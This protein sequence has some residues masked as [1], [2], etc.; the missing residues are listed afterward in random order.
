MLCC[1]CYSEMNLIKIF[2]VGTNENVYFLHKDDDER[3]KRKAYFFLGRRLLIVFSFHQ[4]LS[5]H[6][7]YSLAI[8]TG[9]AIMRA[10]LMDLLPAYS[11]LLKL[12]CVRIVPGLFRRKE[13]VFIDPTPSAFYRISWSL[14][15]S[16]R[17]DYFAYLFLALITHHFCY[18]QTLLEQN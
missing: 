9:L 7:A 10:T 5:T 12:G 8:R 14:L 15:P 17:R 11:A 3:R 1:R 4:F 2:V 16:V 18:F 13:L 6:G